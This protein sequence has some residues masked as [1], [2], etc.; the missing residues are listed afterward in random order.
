ML[1]FWKLVAQKISTKDWHWDYIPAMKLTLGV[2]ETLSLLQ[3]NCRLKTY[4][5]G[6]P[7]KIGTELR[8]FS[9]VG[10]ALYI[11][12]RFQKI[13]LSLSDGASARVL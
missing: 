5:R 2:T 13:T 10:T 1:G 9:A 8:F 7:E 4:P 3:Q 6:C 11:G 12:K